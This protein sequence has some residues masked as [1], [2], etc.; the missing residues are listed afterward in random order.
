MTSI[1]RYEFIVFFFGAITF[2]IEWSVCLY[3][4]RHILEATKRSQGQLRR[5]TTVPRR[6]ETGGNISDSTLR[7]NYLSMDNGDPCGE[8]IVGKLD[9]GGL[10]ED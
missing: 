10:S 6:T 4:N 2:E 8:C 9:S 7:R 5:P 3:G 1:K